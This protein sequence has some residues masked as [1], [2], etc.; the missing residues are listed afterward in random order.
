MADEPEEGSA[1]TGETISRLLKLR[2]LTSVRHVRRARARLLE[3]VADGVIDVERGRAINNGLADVRRDIQAE[4]EITRLPAIEQR[5]EE[6]ARL[7]PSVLHQHAHV[8]V[9]RAG[10]DDA[11]EAALLP[12][13]ERAA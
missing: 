5:I 2:R 10:A 6:L 4:L 13:A 3:M 8:H 7:P 12:F 9:G 1:P 11:S